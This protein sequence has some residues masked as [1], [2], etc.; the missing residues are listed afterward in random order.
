MTQ[1]MTSAS[2]R[3]VSWETAFRVSQEKLLSGTC[4]TFNRG[5]VTSVS[6]HHTDHLGWYEPTHYKPIK[7]YQKCITFF[8]KL[9][10]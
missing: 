4:P 10:T 6:V 1:L 7:L 3:D 8:Q 9:F 5:I 2:I